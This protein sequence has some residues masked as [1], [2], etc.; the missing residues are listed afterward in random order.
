MKTKKNKIEKKRTKQKRKRYKNQKEYNQFLNHSQLFRFRSSS[1][2]SISLK[3]SILFISSSVRL[4]IF[5]G[6]PFF[7]IA[8]P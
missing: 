2:L 6:V 3:K 4:S 1:F 7:T 8:T 5:S